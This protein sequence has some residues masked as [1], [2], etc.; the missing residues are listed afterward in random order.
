MHSVGGHEEIEGESGAGG[1]PGES[2]G[3]RELS[4]FLREIESMSSPPLEGM[5]ARDILEAH[6]LYEQ[7]RGLQLD[8][9][10]V[11]NVEHVFVAPLGDAELGLN[12]NASKEVSFF[13]NRKTNRET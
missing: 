2:M 11:E 7:G 10:D 4:H 9:E 8:D 6:R 13:S 12:P 3:R 5:T 1:E